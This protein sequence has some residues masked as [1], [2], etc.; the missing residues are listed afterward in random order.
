[1]EKIKL[2]LMLGGGGS[3]G[4]YQVGVIKA[5]EEA[6]ILGLVKVISGTSIGAINTMILMS[7]AN[8]AK[9]SEIWEHLDN[10][11]VFGG[12]LKYDT[13]KQNLFSLEPLYEKLCSYVSEKK[14]RKSPIIGYATAAQMLTKE[15]NI[16]TQLLPS[17]M[18]AVHFKL[19]TFHQ[20]HKAVL[21]SASIPVLFGITHIDGIPYVDGGAVDNYPMQPLLDEGCNVIFAI[22]IDA[23]FNVNLYEKFDINLID[24]SSKQAF[25]R[26]VLLDLIE[27]IRFT[28][29]VKESK[30]ELGYLVGKLMINKLWENGLIK[31]NKDRMYLARQKGFK[32]LMLNKDEE[33]EIKMYKQQLNQKLAETKKQAN[34]KTKTKGDK[35]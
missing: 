6:G 7:K 3:K 20:P 17:T 2:G 27:S 19:N 18:E 25:S 28:N 35:K 10:Q 22:A 8:H 9:I 24:F 13:K 4:S 26:S 29:E 1:M 32:A 15:H 12:G 5:L 14:V 33:T 11:N 23:R 30:H 34:I 16:L 31:K 21:A